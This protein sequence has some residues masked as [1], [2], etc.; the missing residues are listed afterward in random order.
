MAVTVTLLSLSVLTSTSKADAPRNGPPGPPTRLT[1]DDDAAPLAVTG[2]PEFGWV[3]VDRDRG[4]VQSAY[5]IVVSDGNSTLL[6]THKVQSNQQ[7][8]VHVPGLENRLQPDHPY[9]W[10]VRTWNAG[11]KVGPYAAV[12]R[13]DTGLTDSDWHASW[14]RRPGADKQVL[15]DYSLFRKD[16]AITASP[17]ARARVYASAGDHY[18]LR[19][20][21][22]LVAHGPS[23]A[24]PDE[25][26]YETTDVTSELR[27]G[28]ANSIAFVTLWGQPSQGRPPTVPALIAHITIDHADG[29][30]QTVTTDGT[31][32]THN[33][34]WVQDVL[35]NDEGDFVEHIDERLVPV[36]WDRAGFDDASWTPAA[37]IGPHPTKPFTHLIAART[38]IVTE[39]MKPVKLSRLGDGS[40]VADFGTVMAA[41]PG[42]DVKHGVAGRK[43]TLLGGFLLDPNGHVS[44][45]RGV[46][47]TNMAWNFDERAGAQELRPFGYLAFRYLEVDGAQEPFTPSSVAIDARHA[48][49]PDEQAA[50]FRSSNPT[51]NAVW[52]LARHSALYD[53]QEQFLDT[54]TREKGPFL[55]D[56]FDVS[57]ATMDA[58]G[59]RS[60]T[61]QALRDFARSQV[62]YWSGQGRVNVV[63]PNGDGKRDIPDGTED[64]PLWVERAYETSGS[65]DELRAMYPTAR[66]ITDYVAH[67]I[68]P[69]TGL[70][71]NLPGGGSDYLYGAVDWPPQMR[72]GY[73]MNTAARTT[74]N[75][76][77]Y[78]DFVR[79]ATLARA[80]GRTADEQTETTRANAL[81]TAIRAH[82]ERADGVF[83]DGL[84]AAGHPS[85]HA[86][87]QANA[88]PLAFGLVE[89][90]KVE[91]VARHVISLGSA[92][93]VGIYWV[94]LDALHE[95]GNDQALV[96]LLT[97]ANQPGYAQILSEGATFTWES[98]DARQIG[99]SESHGWGSAVLSRMQDD[100][101]GVHLL[102]PGAAQVEVR[103]PQANVT[104]ASGT[105]ATQ[106]GPITV[107]WTRNAS[108]RETLDLTVPP[109][110]QALV[111]LHAPSVD[112]VSDGDRPV[113]GDAG[114]SASQA[115]DGLVQL[116]AGSGSYHFTNQAPTLP[117]VAAS[118][119]S[120]SSSKV[121]LIIGFGALVLVG[122]GV[123]MALALRAKRGRSEPS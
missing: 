50:S 16:V 4:S 95:S 44:R 25:Q 2:D 30:R 18:D 96:D 31:W 102:Q 12:A 26:Y 5:E 13:F 6:D 45:T 47:E 72:Y 70:V 86:S 92:T 61:F 90:P 111:H 116:T 41:T 91:A 17:I 104:K 108:D 29:T 60:L 48:D 79:T 24:Y 83:I 59:E 52:N 106:R 71:T 109:N 69:R 33:G 118:S 37:V 40:Y 94:L 122:I 110:V 93:G 73:D 107:A 32:R 27:A 7:S 119:S 101:L 66:N 43:V 82:L 97:N 112:R 117:A 84:D 23:Y 19:V 74:V 114:V 9:R 65:L 76:L 49:M 21:G 20:N 42:V 10:T 88:F 53:S 75:V 123:G 64:Y 78:A 36:S 51:L 8:Y 81:A 100:L 115:T 87:Q 3:V 98:W 77:A 55:G 14:I 1:V 63:Y 67:A 68:D 80:L 38:H 85:A 39:R 56:S 11:G 89:T 22:T 121:G 62:R 105:Y 120:S 46:Q 34:P 58:F 113:T 99:D 54:P 57:Q 28:A 103:V 35:R 15:Q